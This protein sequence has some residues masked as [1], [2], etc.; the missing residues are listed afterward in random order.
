MAPWEKKGF[1]K[2]N[3]KTQNQSQKKVLHQAK[4]KQADIE[5]LATKDMLLVFGDRLAAQ[6]EKKEKNIYPEKLKRTPL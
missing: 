6:W 2:T 4:Q 5:Q 3:E 1:T